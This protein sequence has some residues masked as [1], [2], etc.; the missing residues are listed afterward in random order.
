MRNSWA[1]KLGFL[2]GRDELRDLAIQNLDWNLDW[3]LRI[4]MGGSTNGS[5]PIQ[6][7]FK[8]LD[9]RDE[10]RDLTFFIAYPCQPPSP[11][12]L[13]SFQSYSRKST[14]Q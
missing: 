11:L 9:G 10:L 5:Q 14:N 4:W 2:D 12:T 3:L 13:P 7:L 1:K 6:V 8:N